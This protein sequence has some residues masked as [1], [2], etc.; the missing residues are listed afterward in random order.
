MVILANTRMRKP[1]RAGRYQN[2][3]TGYR[4]FLFLR[5]VAVVATEATTKA[6]QIANM[7]EAHRGLIS[8]EMGRA[9]GNALALHERL[10]E[11][12][13]VSVNDVVDLTGAAFAT[14]NRLVDGLC[15]LGILRETTGQRRNRV[16][17]YD[18]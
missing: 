16:F 12:P 2:Q 1:G 3:L 10:F 15:E 5:R 7:R 9:S 14:A 11:R 8:S 6:R 13:I 17:A 18:P 4:G